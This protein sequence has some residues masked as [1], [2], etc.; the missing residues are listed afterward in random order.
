VDLYIYMLYTYKYIYNIQNLVFITIEIKT[1]SFINPHFENTLDIQMMKGFKNVLFGG[2][3]LF[4]TT[5]TGPGTVW[6]QGQPPERMISEIIRRVPSGG[7]LG[8][9]LGGTGSGGEDGGDGEGG[10]SGDSDS[11]K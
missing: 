9:V 2:E 1:K 10:E 11:T 5:L 6:L 7:G 8:V 3:G 4:F